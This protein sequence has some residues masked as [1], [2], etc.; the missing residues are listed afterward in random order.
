MPASEERM[1]QAL[2][3]KPRRAATF[4]VKSRKG[5]PT[6]FQRVCGAKPRVKRYPMPK[7]GDFQGS[8]PRGTKPAASLLIESATDTVRFHHVTVL[9]RGFLQ[10]AFLLPL[11]IRWIPIG[12]VFGNGWVELTDMRHRRR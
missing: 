12:P 1:V 10:Q 2:T 9:H 4:K 11:Q 5:V 7:C 8:D 6:T 3:G